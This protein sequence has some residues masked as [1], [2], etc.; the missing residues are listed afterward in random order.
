MATRAQGL[1]LGVLLVIV[2]L[3][4]WAMHKPAADTG[5]TPTWDDWRTLVGQPTT[6]PDAPATTQI[7]YYLARPDTVA[8]PPGAVYGVD[9]F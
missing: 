9:W 2:F 6:P 8:P 3:A 1:G 5:S 4:I 7:P